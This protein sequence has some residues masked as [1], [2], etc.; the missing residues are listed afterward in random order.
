MRFHPY[1]WATG[2]W[3]LRTPPE[4]AR[5]RVNSV[6]AML[7]QLEHGGMVLPVTLLPLDHV[8]PS[9]PATQV[10]PQHPQ[11]KENKTDGDDLM[12]REQ[13]NFEYEH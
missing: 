2:P 11:W 7:R 1:G 3:E 4:G 10:R 6:N 13:P 5:L 12:P 8:V 9:P